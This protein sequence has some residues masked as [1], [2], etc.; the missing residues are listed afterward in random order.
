MRELA[1]ALVS[2][3]GREVTAREN[4][5][6]AEIDQL[7][8]TQAAPAIEAKTAAEVDAPLSALQKALQ[9]AEYRRQGSGAQAAQQSL[10][11]AV[12][13]LTHW[14]DYLAAKEAGKM[15]L[16]RSALSNLT[17]SGRQY[18]FASR[19]KLLALQNASSRSPGSG[20]GVSWSSTNDG[21]VFAEDGTSISEYLMTIKT[22]DD[23]LAAKPTLEVGHRAS[24]SEEATLVSA[25]VS[26]ADSYSR[27]K[28]GEASTWNIMSTDALYSPKLA[29]LWGPFFAFALPRVLSLDAGAGAPKPGENIAVC[30]KRMLAEARQAKDWELASRIVSAGRSLNIRDFATTKDSTAF[31][32]F[33]TG[34]NQERAKQFA[35]AVVSFQSALKTGSSIVPP[36]VIGEHLQQIRK[37][38]PEEFQQGLQ[39]TLTGP[40]QSAT[41]RP[42]SAVGTN[43]PAGRTT[44][45]DPKGKTAP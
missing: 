15:D 44:T 31:L 29:H 28:T 16:A 32:Q 34:L 23:L 12:E 11:N 42:A 14:Q 21:P 41:D 38:H 2:E 3:A 39:A 25:A 22:L 4:K 27:M 8:K 36:E 30:L 18:S 45:T 1:K 13:F 7:I 26:L 24:N 5:A 33:T 6:A 43:E 10:R 40:I 9:Q 17:S 35:P 19:S 37:E 20:P